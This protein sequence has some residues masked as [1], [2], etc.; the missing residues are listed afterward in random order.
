MRLVFA[1][2]LLSACA[3][4]SSFTKVTD[5]GGVYESSITGRVCDRS[6][7]VWLE[8]ATVY[9]HIIVDD[10]LVGT[11]ESLTDADGWF[12]LTELRGDS[13][14]TVYVQHGSEVVDMFDV[15]IDGTEE[16]LLPEPDCSSASAAAV[17]VVSGDYD[18]VAAVLSRFGISGVYSVNGQT[19]TELAQFLESAD[20]LAQFEAVM[21]AGGHIEEDVFYDTDGVDGGE[22]SAVL[23]A[24]RAYVEAGG[25]I[26]ATD[27]SYDVIEQLWPN[28]LEWWGD[29]AVPNDAQVG[30][31]GGLDAIVRDRELEEALGTDVVPIDFDLDTW[32]IP[33]SAGEGVTVFQT[34][35]ANWLQGMESG[36][37]ADAPIA[38]RFEVGSGKV[39]FTSWTLDANADDGEAVI[40]YLLERL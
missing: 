23:D 15:T 33:E 4:D 18:E 13:S 32:P 38:V 9:T 24:L 7:N 34:V 35:D 12:H 19:G 10:E 30:V 25:T 14:Y 21:F 6:R 20:N 5:Y 3:N 26:W 27:W 37:T 11:A 22:V 2:T 36:R 28:K 40:R 8:G 1:L 17:A 31:P 39:L 29:D 16:I